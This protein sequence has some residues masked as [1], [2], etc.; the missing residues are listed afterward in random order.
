MARRARLVLG[1]AVVIGV[2]AWPA[3]PEAS[4]NAQ[5]VA[6]GPAARDSALRDSTGILRA[7]RKAQVTFERVRRQHLPR[8]YAVS[9]PRC[10]ETIGRFCYWDDDSTDDEL[11]RTVPPQEPARIGQARELL[12]E[13]LDRAGVLLP[14]DDWIV[15]M[16]VHYLVEAG[17]LD[18]AARRA[19]D[20]RATS[21]WCDALGGLAEHA[22]WRY[23]AADSLFARALATMP[24]AERCDWT[25]LEVLVDDASRERYRRVACG[26]RPALNGRVWWLAD[27]LYLR[28]GNDR[29][30]EH[31]ARVTRARIHRRAVSGY[32]LPWRDDLDEIVRRYGWPSHFSQE[33]VPTGR[34]DPPRVTAY[35]ESPSYHF[36][37]DT[38]LMADA[39][40]FTDSSWTLR[41][42]H[43][44]ERYAPPYGTLAALTHQMSLFRRGDS[45]LLLV[46]YD[47]SADS[48]LG[49]SPVTAAI[50]ASRGPAALAD[51]RMVRH[52][53]PAR[54]TLLLSAPDTALLASVELLAGA[55]MRRARFGVGFPDASPRR[56]RMS[57]IALFDPV[58][59]VPDDLEALLPLARA[60]A[61]VTVGAK[62]GLF[63]ELYGAVGTADDVT[64]N[65][66]IV[67]DGGGWLRRAG[68]RVGLLGPPGRVKFGWRES[69][70]G[71]SI[72]PRAF[73][74]DLEGLDPGRYRIEVTL[75]PD[76]ESPLVESRR[77]EITR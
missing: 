69:P 75:T 32:G 70:R 47:A 16:H 35:H 43:P 23:A 46:A 6:S 21:W 20:C 71:G 24:E 42:V 9:A 2:T 55:R 19:H 17:R 74:V 40:A 36:L 11:V 25:N 62:L 10:G 63:W 41:P 73:V 37:A 1:T 30:T 4:A 7:A 44:R 49:T 39:R 64:L 45:V 58:G 33:I 8:Q 60:S 76:G 28:P 57:D 51:I 26:E 12:L 18:E 13:Q 27:P 3:R 67:R 29:R 61:T 5:Q 14:A 72:A 65:V 38:S 59:T 66:E 31:F 52:G 68:E 50:I 48:L 22:A 77:I 34:T 54:G 15:G 56:L 53:A